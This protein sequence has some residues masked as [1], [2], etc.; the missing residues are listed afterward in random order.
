IIKANKE[1]IKISKENNIKEILID[2]LILNDN[3]INDLCN[4]IKQIKELKDPIGEYISTETLSNG[5]KVCKKRVP[6]GVIGMIYEARPNVT[7]DGFS[8][9]IKS[10][11]VVILKGG[12][13]A[14]NTNKVIVKYLRQSIKELGYDENFIQ[15]IEDTNRETTMNMMKMNNYIDV[16][17]PRGGA[18]LIKTVLENST[19]PVIETGV[20]NCHIFIDETADFNKALKI[21]LNAKAQRP[22][23]CNALETLLVHKNI[24]NEILP[25]LADEL[26]KN[27]IEI[28]ADEKAKK[29]ILKEEIKLACE[30]DWE[31]EFLDY[32]L[33]IKIVDNIEE[34]I[35]HITKYST[36]HSEA[37]ITENYT[38]ANKFTEEIDSAVVYVN[39]STRFTDG[40]EFEFGAEIGIST[41]KLHCR[42]PMGLKE[43]TSYKY[44]VFG[45]GQIR[46]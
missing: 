17:I 2:R 25:I 29:I 9:C 18:G 30:K 7:V 45:D 16:L 40:G 1:D 20:G 37:I 34:A 24:A 5:L 35:L 26:L 19:I 14:I 8:I 31:E 36:G 28:R 21:V 11:N 15:L 4:A 23:V 10:S 42:G 13:E 38:N 3:R 33:A 6:I 27:G 12:K 32:I 41:Q 39:S 43:I 46:E 44:I 22:S